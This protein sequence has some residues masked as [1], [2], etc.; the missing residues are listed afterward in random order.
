[1]KLQSLLE[2]LHFRLWQEGMS[3]DTNANAGLSLAG[4]KSAV[5][6]KN[7]DTRTG[8]NMHASWLAPLKTM[9]RVWHPHMADPLEA[10]R[11]FIAPARDLLLARCRA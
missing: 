5:I 9:K 3:P 11:F 10:G 4:R 7:D 8:K 1:M 2:R 6:K